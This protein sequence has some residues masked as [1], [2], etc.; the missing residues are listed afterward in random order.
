[1]KIEIPWEI[2]DIFFYFCLNELRT[3]RIRTINY[4]RK[5]DL[6]DI[7]FVRGDKSDRDHRGDEIFPTVEDAVCHLQAEYDEHIKNLIERYK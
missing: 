4:I 5:E 3:D 1:M 2:G 6:P 7:L